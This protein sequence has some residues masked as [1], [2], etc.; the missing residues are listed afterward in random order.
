MALDAKMPV[1]FDELCRGVIRDYLHAMFSVKAML[2]VVDKGVAAIAEDDFARCF[3]GLLDHPDSALLVQIKGNVATV[4]AAA[5]LVF[6]HSAYENAVFDL[7]KRLVMYDPEPWLKFIA[8]KQVAFE[9][10]L[11]VGVSAIQ[12]DLLADWL[13]V[14]EKESLPKKVERVLA[15]LQ[16]GSLKDVIQGFDFDMEELKKIDQLRHDVTH[17]PNFANPIQDVTDKLRFLHCTVLLLKKLAGQKYQEIKK[18][19][20]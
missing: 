4:A 19:T 11:S 17:K 20:S 8:K 6:M 16:P 9:K 15:V 2:R 10:V 18:G 7:I 5:G 13:E 14:V 3:D 12:S 1:L